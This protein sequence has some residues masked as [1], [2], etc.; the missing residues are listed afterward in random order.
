MPE[1]YLNKTIKCEGCKAEFSAFEYVVRRKLPDINDNICNGETQKA[2]K[3]QTRYKPE[4][5]ISITVLF[6]VILAGYFYLN[7]VDKQKTRSDEAVRKLEI[8]ENKF[9]GLFEALEIYDEE[10]RKAI[11]HKTINLLKETGTRLE[12]VLPITEAYARAYKGRVDSGQMSQSQYDEGLKGVVNWSALHPSADTPEIINL[13]AVWEI[14]DSQQQG[15]FCRMVAA[16]AK[17]AN[18]T[19][20]NFVKA[21]SYSYSTAKIMNWTPQETIEAVAKIAKGEPERQQLPLVIETMDALSH[22][23]IP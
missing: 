4:T 10:S 15:A 7:M 21:L 6:F 16:G 20:I 2:G 18:M 23:K 14:T 9:S 11:M 13:M 5:I 8:L 19:I 17:W 12:V 1:H 3:T 22:P